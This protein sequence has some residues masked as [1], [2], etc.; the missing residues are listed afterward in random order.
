[1]EE[2]SSNLLF[3][4]DAETIGS[5]IRTLPSFPEFNVVSHPM[6]QTNN[7]DILSCGGQ[8]KKICYVLRDGNW[9]KHSTLNLARNGAVAIQMANGTYIFGGITSP[10]TS[11]FLP[12]NATVWQK[13]PNIPFFYCSLISL[14]SIMKKI[15]IMPHT[16]EHKANGHAI[17][18]VE[19]LLIQEDH[20]IKVNC[21]ISH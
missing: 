14:A 1:M 10:S 11:E 3:C 19:L 8:S 2:D 20:I 7:G 21:Y 5:T 4:N 16:Y 6:V 9:V 18:N 15:S 13:G 17:S 12:N